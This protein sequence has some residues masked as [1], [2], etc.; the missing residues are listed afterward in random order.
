MQSSDIHLLTNFRILLLVVL[1]VLIYC[2]TK[3]S[4]RTLDK[5]WRL[6]IIY[7]QDSE[8]SKGEL[9]ER[10][11]LL[12]TLSMRWSLLT[13]IDYSLGTLLI[14]ELVLGAT[15][16]GQGLA[17]YF[18]VHVPSAVGISTAIGSLLALLV[19]GFRSP[20]RSGRIEPLKHLLRNLDSLVSA[21]MAGDTTMPEDTEEI[22]LK[23]VK[24]EIERFMDFREM[25]DAECGRLLEYLSR[26]EGIVGQAASALLW[27]HGF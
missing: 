17:Y 6:S 5:A 1:L 9:R 2:S 10:D 27:P 16:A 11:S 14:Y 26:R 20:F 8:A 18:W 24:Q 21:A 7:P 23:A 15:A 13:V 3:Q 4:G 12:Q 25:G 22:L 19:T